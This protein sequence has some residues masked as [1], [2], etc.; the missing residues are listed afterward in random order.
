MS[1][2]SL[3]NPSWHSTLRQEDG[4]LSIGSG[5][6]GVQKLVGAAAM[7]IQESFM[8]MTMAVMAEKD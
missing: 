8:A 3:L 2:K 1:N 7:A 4:S 6:S 5:V